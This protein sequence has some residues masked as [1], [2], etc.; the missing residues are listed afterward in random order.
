MSVAVYTVKTASGEVVDISTVGWKV[1]TDVLLYTHYW[2]KRSGYGG[3]FPPLGCYWAL[4]P[5]FY[6]RNSL[7]RG[8]TRYGSGKPFCDCLEIGITE[9][10]AR[11]S[12]VSCAFAS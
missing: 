2:W 1:S 10:I 7:Q 3:N 12:E 5:C 6:L 9:D 4:F 8:A 11:V